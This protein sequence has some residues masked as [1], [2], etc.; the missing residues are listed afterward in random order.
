MAFNYSPKIVTDGLVLCLDAGNIKSFV[1]G[2]TTWRDLTTNNSNGTLTN[3]PIYNS[4]N[5]GSI[6]FD[7]TDDYVATSTV[8]CNSN[9]NTTISYWINCNSFSAVAGAGSI[10]QDS[11]ITST[12]WNGTFDTLFYN[13]A[14]KQLVTPLL[15]NTFYHITL[16]TTNYLIYVNGVLANTQNVSYGWGTDV[17]SPRIGKNRYNSFSGKMYIFSVYNR[18]LT[19]AEIRQNYN[20]TKGRF[21]L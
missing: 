1:S 13:V 12:C 6:Q 7:G 3:G 15:T 8:L 11:N 14:K 5:G 17:V 10:C 9:G 20:A 4:T 2:S 16:D 19:A 21:G 18:I